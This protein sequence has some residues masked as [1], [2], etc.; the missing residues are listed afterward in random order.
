MANERDA[1]LRTA[2][3]APA[4]TRLQ[5][6]SVPT[7]V[8]EKLREAILEGTLKPGD[9][10]LEH[11]LAAT[12]GIG[13]P[14]LREALRELE[15]QGF[16][17]KRD[18]KKGTYVTELDADDFR[19]ILEVRVTLEARA[20]EKAAVNWNAEAEAVL[21]HLVR[22]MEESARTFDL[23]T[24]HKSDIQFHRTI[25]DLAGNK[26][27]GIA[28]ERIAFGLFAFVLVQRPRES[29]N[30]FV[31][32]AQQ[33]REILDALKSGD[34]NAARAGFIQSTARFWSE[35]HQVHFEQPER[36]SRLGKP[37]GLERQQP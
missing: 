28:L 23:A 1:A 33:H 17:R 22:T 8:A 4:I 20:I 29:Q 7:V 18:A 13:Q 11:K 35:C 5:R 34:P 14:T 10:L 26:Y 9:R 15:L 19:N 16:V 37:Q 27:L 21:A 32:A 6:R 31:A 25:W 24:F 12:F 30:E 36:G 2:S 3:S